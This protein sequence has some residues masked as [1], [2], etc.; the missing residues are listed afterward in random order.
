M[1]DPS[2]P[3]QRPPER[4]DA[5]FFNPSQT[6]SEHTRPPQKQFS[7]V[8]DQH[9]SL[10][11][12]DGP[13][14]DDPFAL[15][16]AASYSAL[17]QLYRLV[18]LCIGDQSQVARLL[19]HSRQPGLAPAAA[20]L[21][22]GGYA[23]SFAV[24]VFAVLVNHVRRMLA[25]ALGVGALGGP[26]AT[27]KL[28]VG[29]PALFL[30]EEIEVGFFGR[31]FTSEGA[32]KLLGDIIGTVVFVR[33]LK[34]YSLVKPD[35]Q[36]RSWSGI[37]LDGVRTRAIEKRKTAALVVY[38]VWILGCAE[39]LH[40]RVAH[41]V[42]VG[43]AYFKLLRGGLLHKQALCEVVLPFTSPKPSSLIDSIWETLNIVGFHLELVCFIAWGLYPLIR[44]AIRSTLRLDPSKSR[45]EL[46]MLI[47]AWVW[48]TGYV[49]RYSNKY[50]IGLE[51]S[52][53]LLV[54]W[55]IFAYGIL[56]SLYILDLKLRH[57]T[58]ELSG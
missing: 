38:L 10:R 45:P 40:A 13:L 4:S 5:H 41:I 46:A 55:W 33:V 47:A 1:S 48:G 24:M 27:L 53:L 7:T 37:G 6:V 31:V 56:L 19:S 22:G 52:G 42:A 32:W 14:S 17:A 51:I 44:L 16:P 20:A 12:T 50:Y 25:P 9:G 15:I 43:I 49:T 29:S 57:S 34:R 18:R 54:M 11:A 35:D 39:Y 21:V 58:R 23:R 8:T 28:A 3:R 26:I 2:L 36:R 30:K